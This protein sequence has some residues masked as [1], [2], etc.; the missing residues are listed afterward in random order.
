MTNKI[1][2]W[3]N[4]RAGWIKFFKDNYKVVRYVVSYFSGDTAAAALDAF[5][6][7]TENETAEKY[8]ELWHILQQAWEDAPDCPSIRGVPGWHA[9]CDLCSEGPILWDDL[10]HIEE[11][12]EIP[13]A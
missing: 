4:S 6:D 3:Y 13:G 5:K 1:E 9:V 7:V 10:L 11:E 8:N 2:K 12:S